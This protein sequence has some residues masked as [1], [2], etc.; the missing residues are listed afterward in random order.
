MRL[1]WPRL[2]ADLTRLK[3]DL[4][5]EVDH[6][7]VGEVVE[8][9][10]AAERLYLKGELTPEYMAKVG[11]ALRAKS[12]RGADKVRDQIVLTMR[13]FKADVAALIVAVLKELAD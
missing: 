1:L 13:Q 10:D 6:E 9:L 3:E 8:L 11:T 5:D 2:K 12:W 7:G 4:E